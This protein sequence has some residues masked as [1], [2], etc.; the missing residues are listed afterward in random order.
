MAKRKLIL[1]LKELPNCPRCGRIFDA[2]YETSMAYTEE[3]FFA[4]LH[5]VPADAAVI[6]FCS[7]REED[8]ENLLRLEAISGPLPVLT[9][10][11]TLNPN[12]IRKAAQRGAAR[13]LVC[14]MEAEKIRDIIH[15]AIRDD[16]LKQYLESLYSQTD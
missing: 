8:V 6:C 16:G 3:Q 7:A 15:D 10:S 12:F 11:K 9:C 4:K 1:Y 13:F 5:N 2:E 14:T